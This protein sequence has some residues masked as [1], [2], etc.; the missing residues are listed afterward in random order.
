MLVIRN[1]QLEALRLSAVSQFEREMI[2]HLYDFSPRHCAVI[3]ETG[4]REVIRA[5]VDRAAEFGFTSYGPV[6]LF[7]ELAFM[8]GIDFA[9]DPQ[10]RWTEPGLTET[11]PGDQM[12]RAELLHTDCLRYL[13]EISG[14]D[15]KFAIR[16][17]RQ[18]R[19]AVS[20][21]P[22]SALDIPRNRLG[23]ALASSLKEIYPE[24]AAYLGDRVLNKIVSR[25]EQLAAQHDID[26]HRGIALL[27]FLVF[28]LGWGCTQDPLY[29]WVQNALVDPLAAPNDRAARLEAKAVVYLDHVLQYLKDQ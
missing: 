24:K 15:H 16:S 28:A 8:F 20:E 17:L 22:P 5:G 6:R 19:K 26:S 13:D 11:M 14:P 1:A 27:V 12:Y 2:D 10:H 23:S 21:I 7:I 18:T 9:K 4:V 25:G 3:R 29:P